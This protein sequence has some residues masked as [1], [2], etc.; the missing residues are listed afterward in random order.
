[1]NNQEGSKI[2]PILNKYNLQPTS[3][4]QIGKVTKVMTNKGI[5]A[6]KSISNKIN[7]SFPTFLQQLFQQ[8][9]TRAVPIYP[10]I[11]GKYLVY[12]NQKFYYLMPWLH[13]DIPD[14]RGDHYHAFFN[15]IARIHLTTA[16]KQ[17]I[18]NEN[19]ITGHYETIIKKWEERNQILERFVEEAEAKWYMS[20]FELQF[21]T[22]F[23]EVSLASSFARNQLD[24][25][26]ELMMEKKSYRTTLTLNNLSDSHFLYDESGKGYLSNF[27]RA[28]YA[29]PTNDLVS[30]YFRILKTYPTLCT[31]CLEW[32]ASYQSR[33]P[34][35]EE[36]FY[37]F[38][39]HLTFPDP[40]Y[41]CVRNYADQKRKKSEREHVQVLQRAY[42]LTKNIEFVSVKLLE[43]EQKRKEQEEEEESHTE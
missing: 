18:D 25:W 29:N 24:K 19:E 22:Y 11:E 35:R 1:M 30:L 7:P 34:L 37:L 27:E 5:Y 31:D 13:S 10:T 28:G 4:E 14:H 15:E 39:S 38:L 16:R 12:D 23:Y 42:W 2:G 40:I 43:A 20:P 26:H 6:L 33:F 9:Y 3:F 17:K 21:C 41:R 32:F 36:E 8:G